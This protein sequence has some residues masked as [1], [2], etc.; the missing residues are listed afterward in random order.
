MKKIHLLSLLL[1]TTTTTSACKS[2]DEEE[3]PNEVVTTTAMPPAHVDPGTTANSEPGVDIDRIG[4]E[5][6]TDELVAALQKPNNADPIYV[7]V[8]PGV[9]IKDERVVVAGAEPVGRATR[10]DG[11]SADKVV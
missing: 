2:Y 9:K 6:T 7:V 4:K 3:A 5:G 1:L 10:L 11:P 8:R